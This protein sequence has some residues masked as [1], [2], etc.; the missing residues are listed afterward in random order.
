MVEFNNRFTRRMGDASARKNHEWRPT[1]QIRLSRPLWARASEEERRE[2]VIH[3]AC[4]IIDYIINGEMCGHGR[5]WK[6][7][8]WKCGIRAERCHEVDRSGLAR[9]RAKVAASCMC[10]AISEIGAIRAKKIREQ[11]AVY[12]C[13]KCSTPVSLA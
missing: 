11:N 6:R 3:E 13:R 8:M 7:L 2:T 4:H 5:L 9:K 12:R 10:G 1:L